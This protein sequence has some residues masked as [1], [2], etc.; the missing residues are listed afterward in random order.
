MPGELDVLEKELTRIRND[1][2]NAATQLLWKHDRDFITECAS[3]IC[4][5]N[6]RVLDVGCGRAGYLVSLIGEE[7]NEGYGIDPL[8]EVSLK[9]AKVI[10][11]EHGLAVHLLCATGENIPFRDGTFDTALVL[12][13]LQHV[14]N[15]D[16]VLLEIR[17][18]L[19]PG[20]RLLVTVPQRRGIYSARRLAAKTLQAVRSQ[21]DIFTMDF[22]SGSLLE[23]LNRNGFSVIKLHG[24]KF[25]P[26]MLPGFLSFLLKLDK[27]NAVIKIMGFSDMLADRAHFLA[28]NLV[29]LCA[30]EKDR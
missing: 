25:L 26:I 11:D 13:T 16:K 8:L 28:S 7:A 19:K 6:F 2:V 20:G 30:K 5:D 12:S 27:E 24:R 1:G 3:S 23:I 18:V 14:E 22:S 29:A 9:P 15:Q 10:V 4:H 21:E 17:R